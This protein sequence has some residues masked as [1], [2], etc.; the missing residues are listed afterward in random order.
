MA[1]VEGLPLK[2]ATIILDITFSMLFS[3]FR[4]QRLSNNHLTPL[5]LVIEFIR[6]GTNTEVQLLSGSR[7]FKI[8]DPHG[9]D[10][11][12]IQNMKVDS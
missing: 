12:C 5:V 8:S 10:C 4:A 3:D 7:C 2:L 1:V 11:F 9:T 6:A